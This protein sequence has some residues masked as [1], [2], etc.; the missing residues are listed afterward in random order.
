MDKINPILKDVN[1]HNP[2]GDSDFNHHFDLS[3][4]DNPSYKRE[5]SH[6]DFNPNNEA[7]N[8]QAIKAPNEFKEGMD[9]NWL[10]ITISLVDNRVLRRILNLDVCRNEPIKGFD[11]FKRQLCDKF[12]NTVKFKSTVNWDQLSA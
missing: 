2:N 4:W 1:R 8:S 3:V 6:A 11:S 10:D 12:T 5:A 9:S 7:R